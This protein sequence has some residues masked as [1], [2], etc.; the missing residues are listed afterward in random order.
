MAGLSL[1]V[2]INSLNSLNNSQTK[3]QLSPFFNWGLEVIYKEAG[4]SST[5]RAY[6]L[7]PPCVPFSASEAR[8][9]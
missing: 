7:L 9:G 8:G 1:S 4:P 6:A 3:V 2:Y 5:V